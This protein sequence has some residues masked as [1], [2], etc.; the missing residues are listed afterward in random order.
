MR[1]AHG[2]RIKPLRERLG[3]T[4]RALADALGV[5]PNTVA[6]WERGE[7]GISPAMVA[8]LEQVAS[9]RPS[10]TVVTR[11]SAVILDP[12]HGA[13]LDAL[14]RK[15]DPDV[16]EAC[17]AALLRRDYPTL[18]PVRGGA[19]DGFDG[20]VADPSG[21]P[22][23]LITTTGEKL[24]SNLRRNLDRTINRGWSVARLLFATPRRITPTTRKNLFKAARE[25]G[26]TL[27]QTYDQDWFAQSLCREPEWCK[28]LLRVTGR[29]SALSLFPLTQRPVLGDAVLGREQEIRWLLEQKGDCLLTGEPGS[30]KTFLL[31]RTL[32]LQGYG[33]FLVDGDR[34]QIANDLRSLRPPAVIVDDAHVNPAQ[35][36]ELV[37]IRSEVGAEFRIVAT[38]WPGFSDPVRIA[39]QI[40]TAAVRDLGRLD[41]NTMVDIIRSSG[42]RGPDRLLYVI[43]KQ[44][45][46]RPGLAATLA[47]LC[48]TGNVEDVVN[49]ESLLQELYRGFRKMIGDNGIFHIA[50]F[51]LG[52]AAG[53]N[54]DAVSRSLGVPPLELRQAL[55]SL[56]SAGVVSERTDRAISVE[57]EPLRWSIVKR[58]FFDAPLLLDID[59]FLSIVENRRNALQTL[60]GVRYRG[61]TIPELE[62]WLEKEN[63]SD[64]WSVYASLGAAEARY[65]LRRY[66]EIT[67]EVAQ[68]ALSSAP[69]TAIPRLLERVSDKDVA[70]R[71]ANIGRLPQVGP[72]S[73]LDQLKTWAKAIS[74]EGE[75]ALERRL[76]IV[77]ATISWWKS[78]G[79]GRTAIRALCIALL[80][81]LDYSALDP[82][83]GNKF[84][85]VSRILHEK[86]LSKLIAH[87]SEVLEVVSGTKHVPWNDLFDLVEAWLVPQARFFPPV[88]ISTATDERLRNFAAT[89]LKDLCRCSNQHPGVQHQIGQLAMRV[90]VSTD[91]KLCPAFEILCPLES[92]D[93]KNWKS[94]HRQWSE[95]TSRLAQ[96]W[97]N[98]PVGDVA[99]FLRWFEDEADLAGIQHPRL[100]YLFCEYLAE[101]VPDPVAVAEELIRDRLPSELVAPFLRYAAIRNRPGW[102]TL[103][104][105]CLREER[106]R[107]IA[108]ETVLKHQA[109]PCQLLTEAISKA[110]EI[111]DLRGFI[112]ASFPSVPKTTITAMI[113]SDDRRVAV[114]TA[115][116]YWQENRG[117]IPKSIRPAWREALLQSAGG[118]DSSGSDTYW[119]H[120]ILSMDAA[121]AVDWLVLHMTGPDSTSGWTKWD[122][123]KKVAGAL[124]PKQRGIVLARVIGAGGTYYSSEVISE[125]VGGDIGLYNQ[126]LDSKSLEEL[127]LDPLAGAPDNRWRELALAARDR[128]YSAEDVAYA[129]I[130]RGGS[131]VG[132]ESER[133]IRRRQ[134][135]EALYDDPDDRIAEVGRLCVEYTTYREGVALTREREE[136]IAGRH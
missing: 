90:S 72:E 135:F 125:L 64:L 96:A 110:A 129:T 75:H 4:Q 23:P 106:F 13:V 49:G 120:E 61:A 131:W 22:F 89:M 56:G 65:V 38:S 63:S 14:K 93:S 27:V 77:R 107:S 78:N 39:L 115:G 102:H 3:L 124:D 11:S 58:A 40:G 82:G 122:L 35:I 103:A 43:R 105:L 98:R 18:V 45:A 32:A 101:L 79:N 47:H 83:I 92:F 8:R 71:D 114:A 37:Q 50:P 16:F 66:P 108:V 85:R 73:T 118:A 41:A 95:A 128:G 121:L 52:G 104:F 116:A 126:L 112:M 24:V 60:I 136:A 20:A 31:L 127:H 2:S 10:G 69:E 15:L 99:T 123:A 76:A 117:G 9:S 1:M 12:H 133:W 132:P 54:L 94:Q 87:W 55:A 29:P 111:P 84:K 67:L 26:V 130:G 19:D 5:H 57:P 80:P 91:L 34:T 33:R 42:V 62:E 7:L 30:G 28:R 109:H 25:R 59:P 68:S 6:R 100:S 51:A 21:E 97:K 113:R 53:V 70:T 17:A 48:I 74:S 36:T 86:E 44:A 134:P 46:G 88:K 119:I 81:G